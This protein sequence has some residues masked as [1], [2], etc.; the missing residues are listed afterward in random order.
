[1]GKHLQD[2]PARGV[3]GRRDELPSH[4]TV[5]LTPEEPRLLRERAQ[6]PYFS[7]II[8]TLTASGIRWGE[9]VEL[10]RKDLARTR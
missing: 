4:E 10:R 3:L 2:N 5:Y 7:L 6:T 8:W 9:L 1:M